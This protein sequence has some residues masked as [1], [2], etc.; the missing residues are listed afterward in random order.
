MSSYDF[1]FS[2]PLINTGFVVVGSGLSRGKWGEGWPSGLSYIDASVN[3]TWAGLVYTTGDGT[4]GFLRLYPTLNHQTTV[5]SSIPDAE[6]LYIGWNISEGG[7]ANYTL[8]APGL[9]KLAT[10][11]ANAPLSFTVVGDFGPDTCQEGYVWREAFAGDHV[12]V[13]PETR[14]QPAIDNGLAASR[15]DPHG[16]SG[17]KS[18]VTGYVWRAARPNDDVCV[19]P[20]TRD[21]AAA[22]NAAAKSRLL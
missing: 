7:V 8:T 10:M 3:A 16:G 6:T 14:R 11:S 2:N 12:C 1:S 18:C 15:V 17:A 9:Y 22:D 13:L 20:A 19:T 5:P 21:R 4:E